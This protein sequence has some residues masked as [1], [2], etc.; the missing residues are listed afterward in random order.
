MTEIDDEGL[1]RRLQSSGP[2][3]GVGV[4]FDG[5][6][7]EVGRRRRVRRGVL[8]TG[9]S[10]LTVLAL[11]VGSQVVTRPS[12]SVSAFEE[13][14]SRHGPTRVVASGA[15]SSARGSAVIQPTM[16]Q[17]VAVDASGCPVA[18]EASEVPEPPVGFDLA[19]ALVPPDIPSAVTVCRYAVR[20]LS[21]G[22]TPTV[23]AAPG[24][25]YQLTASVRL[26]GGRERV[27]DDL[28]LVRRSA[29][30]IRP[31]GLVLSASS[32]LALFDYGS[33]RRVWIATQDG[34]CAEATNGTF[35]SD[36]RVAGGLAQALSGGVWLGFDAHAPACEPTSLGRIG[37]DSQLVP[38]DATRV[39]VCRPGVDGGLVP[40]VVGS[41]AGAAV[42]VAALRAL[43]PEP[44]GDCPSM[45][46][47]ARREA[48]SIVVSF[49]AGPEQ[50]V[51]LDPNLCAPVTTDLLKAADPSG[52]VRAAVLSAV[53]S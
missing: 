30:V 35:T 36:A 31:C 44:L 11:V 47:G 14:S 3:A 32:Y 52:S 15:V 24:P 33:G 21:D 26:D 40:S 2:M 8:A 45:G 5:V 7:A 46:S 37:T 23:V 4:D 19:D 42:I 28:R 53:G 20:S 43:T 49:A 25:P 18:W 6:A 27:R 41:A 39:T 1:I 10:A 9:G 29:G 34:P 16:Q 51:T 13:P 48:L 17:Q 22:P 12:A 50:V 38:G